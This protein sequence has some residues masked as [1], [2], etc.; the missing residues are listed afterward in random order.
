MAGATATTNREFLPM[1]KSLY[2]DIEWKDQRWVVDGKLW[3]SGGAGAG[4]DMILTYLFENFDRE[5]VET[6]VCDLLEMHLSGRGQFYDREPKWTKGML[7]TD[8]RRKFGLE[9]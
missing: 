2:P 6:N 4:V 7:E 9:R 3:T 5:F 8:W 1:A